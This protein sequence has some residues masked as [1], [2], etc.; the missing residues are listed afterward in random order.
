MM[1]VMERQAA[2]VIGAY[3]DGTLD[4]DELQGVL[5]GMTW[6]NPD[7]PELALQA[8]LLIAEATSGQRNANDLRTGLAEA[9]RQA[10]THA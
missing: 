6:D 4:L 1:L 8:E 2:D 7:A 5:V 9:L 10:Y 3:L